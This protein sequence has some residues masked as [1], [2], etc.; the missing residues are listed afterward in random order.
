MLPLSE[1]RL[2]AWRG[3]FDPCD[4][5]G[6]TQ[7]HRCRTETGNVTTPHKAR[8]DRARGWDARQPEIDTL[9][10]GIDRRDAAIT[11]LTNGLRAITTERD[12][13]RADVQAL[14]TEVTGL[15][16][17]NTA[18]DRDLAA[19]R[20]EYAAY[21]TSHPDQPKPT[22]RT[23]F[24]AGGSNKD[25]TKD[26]VDIDRWYG[27]P[28]DV[29]KAIT[30]AKANHAAGIR[31]WMSFK[32]PHSWADMAAGKGDTWA[33][34][35]L[36]KLDA[37][38]FETWVAFHHEPEGDGIMPD[39]TKMQDRLSRLVPGGI[40]GR[41]K[42]WLIVTG[43]HQ[44]AGTNAAYKWDAIY[45]KGAPI[46]GIAY[47]QPYPQYGYVWKNGVKTT[48]FANGA[49]T[50]G[51]VYVGHIARRAAEYG[52]KAA[53]GEY[54]YSDEHFDLDPAWLDRTLAAAVDKGLLAVCYFDS[55]LN[56]TKSWNLGAA[57]S[58]KRAYFNR[59]VAAARP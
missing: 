29:T 47:D 6:E 41:V 13:L 57:G 26:G 5:C 1:L 15:T 23:L 44:E 18:L 51:A 20:A 55:P 30:R 53:I 49:R 22:T 59:A 32:V 4:T 35:L 38:G 43:W 10:Q 39:W 28:G 52:V 37:L 8:L 27:G 45:P 17:Q 33:K 42:F 25:R 31:T 2:L 34:D 9:Q 40:D 3:P 21:R 12:D 56:S 11:D 36:G 48:E 16:E 24:G 7:N 50:E 14:N 19:T 46:Y 58:T 54:G